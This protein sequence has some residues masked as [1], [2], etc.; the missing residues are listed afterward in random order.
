VTPVGKRYY[1]AVSPASAFAAQME[2]MWKQGVVTLAKAFFDDVA[3]VTRRFRDDLYN[4]RQFDS[5]KDFCSNCQ[6]FVFVAGQQFDTRS[7]T[8]VMK[9]PKLFPQRNAHAKDFFVNSLIWVV[10]S[11]TKCLTI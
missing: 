9:K 8:N 5:I 6:R 2:V 3:E 4:P 1:G 10:I 11:G 7:F